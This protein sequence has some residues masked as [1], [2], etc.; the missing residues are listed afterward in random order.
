MYQG[1][2]VCDTSKEGMCVHSCTDNNTSSFMK[3]EMTDK[4]II[5]NMFS[6]L[7]DKGS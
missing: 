3:A 1:S 7:Q 5:I 6:S 2:G 4:P